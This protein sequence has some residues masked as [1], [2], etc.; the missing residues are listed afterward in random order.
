M[1][2]SQREKTN[3]QKN[4]ATFCE[5]RSPK[6]G[7]S[8]A[9]RRKIIKSPFG[10]LSAEKVLKPRQ[11]LMSTRVKKRLA[12]P[13]GSYDNPDWL[14]LKEQQPLGFNCLSHKE[15]V[16]I[17]SGGK[18]WPLTIEACVPAVAFKIQN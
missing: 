13:A 18:L 16:S 8:V 14:G 7:V 9:F 6:D 11:P 15:S 1:D 17:Y 10:P 12:S 3:K 2:V 4:P 5:F